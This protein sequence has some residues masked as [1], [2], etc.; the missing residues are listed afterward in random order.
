MDIEELKES[1]RIMF[2]C[3]AGSHAYNL[4][5]PDSDEDL[6]G[7][8]T[9]PL[10]EYGLLEN[11]PEQIHND[12]QDIVY[13]SL[14]RFFHLA[15]TSNP[16]IIELLWMPKETT[17]VCTD[18]MQILLD[19]RD[20]FISKAA[21]R[22]HV[23]YS[24]AQIKKSRGQNKMIHLECPEKKPVKED[25]CFLL[26]S[27]P[28]SIY[29]EHPGKPI[30]IHNLVNLNYFHV[31]AVEHTRHLYR[32]YNY[33]AE[34]KGVFR[35][36]N[37]LVCESIPIEDEYDCFYGF[38]LY[39]EDGYNSALKDYNKYWTWKNN[40]NESRWADKD[41][42]PFDYDH[43]N[44]LHCVRLLRSGENILKNGEPIVRWED[45]DR[46]Y[47]M[48]IRRGEQPYDDLMKWVDA[49]MIELEVLYNSKGCNVPDK[50]DQK[51][52]NKLY[53]ELTS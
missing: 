39:N 12:S 51:K 28:D 21:Y 53:E 5:T 44:I 3:I 31:A 20:L 4:A 33:G 2:E 35:G 45:S 48:S 38:L 52:I 27:D 10:E 50:V 25:F 32:L 7:I 29:G 24:S 36:D 13:Y 14:R 43:K 30:P 26:D 17:K 47:L 6:R 16:N 42:K 22:T 46:E 41:G 1:S 40:R 37:T 19:N 23:A 8:F 15:A 18:K 34:A 11:P 9:V 49:K